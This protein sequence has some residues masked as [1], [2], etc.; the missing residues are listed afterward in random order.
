VPVFK[1][2]RDVT[3]AI[4]RQSQ[5]VANGVDGA[6]KKRSAAGRGKRNHEPFPSNTAFRFLTPSPCHLFLVDSFEPE[7]SCSL[8][9]FLWYSNAFEENPF[10][11]ATNSWCD[12]SIAS[13]GASTTYWTSES[14]EAKEFTDKLLSKD[15]KTLKRLAGRVRKSI[16]DGTAS[17]WL[18]R[19]AS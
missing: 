15:A 12:D 18:E 8:P 14:I 19:D 1:Q 2:G 3:F 13:S 17:H 9:L 10:L 7:V 16:A 5:D 6:Q 4:T 11:T